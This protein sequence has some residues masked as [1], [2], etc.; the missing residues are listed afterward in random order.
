MESDRNNRKPSGGWRSV[1]GSMHAAM[2]DEVAEGVFVWD[3]SGRCMEVNRTGC[4]LLGYRRDEIVGIYFLDLIYKED[5]TRSVLNFDGVLPG[6]RQDPICAHMQ[7]KDGTL[8]PVEIKQRPLADGNVVALVSDISSLRAA[9]ERVRKTSRLSA[10]LRGIH[11][12]MV[13]ETNDNSLFESTCEIAVDVGGFGLAT[14]GL[15]DNEGLNLKMVSWTSAD[16]SNPSRMPMNIVRLPFEA[17]IL[18]DVIATGKVATTTDLQSVL[19]QMYSGTETKLPSFT[20]GA[21]IPIRRNGSV[22]GLLI[23]GS[24]DTRPM[25]REERAILE[26][27]GEEISFAVDALELRSEMRAL[28]EPSLERF[29]SIM[30]RLSDTVTIL[31]GDEKIIFISRGLE[32]MIGYNS[33]EITGGSF[34]NI[35]FEDDRETASREFAEILQTGKSV[36]ALELRLKR[37][38]GRLVYVEVDATIYKSGSL[39]GIMAVLR[40]VSERKRS[41]TESRTLETNRVE[42]ERQ[43]QQAQR[44]GSIGTLAGGIAHDFN[45]LF[46]IIMGYSMLLRRKKPDEAKLEKGLDSIQNAADRGA[47]LVKQLLTIARKTETVFSPLNVNDIVIEVANKLEEIFPKSISI[48]KTLQ[49]KIPTV[50]ADSGQ[51]NQV[52]MNL[53]MNSKDAMPAGGTL[54]ISTKVAAGDSLRAAY[55]AVESGSYVVLEVADDGTGMSEDTKHRIFDPFFTTK[56]PGK[57]TGLGL[58]LVY[59][60]MESHRG[61][62]DVESEEGRGTIFSLY[63]PVDSLSDEKASRNPEEQSEEIR[64]GRETIFVIEDEEMLQDIMR[65]FLAP[66]GYN[67][68][69]ARDGE[70]ALQIYSERAREIDLV[71]LDLGL[72]KIDGEQ[73]VDR[74]WSIR[75]GAK[76]V[77]A[78]GFVDSETHEKLL[79]AGVISFIPKPYSLRQVLG[80]VREALDLKRR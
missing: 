9:E 33:G 26:E 50:L 27:I 15:L 13:R 5:L 66:K 73:V 47:T 62:I 71:V 28:G 72:P 6:G 11:H 64:G 23:L 8:L 54:S 10:T 17:N 77:V 34:R 35:I 61:W 29:M 80:T 78:S 51:L 12:V 4:N 53:G 56:M 39:T 7:R 46:G 43:L 69:G 79:G 48:S 37:R 44:L 74:I 20:L 19:R 3:R 18:N 70:E 65:N 59:S 67:V 30:D 2:L 57:G 16:G 76:V 45:N 52:L 1:D 42:R 63:F 55:P 38:D 75:P 58:A 14:I 24:D 22:I 68:I 32:S 31:N 60:I 21:G 40:D 25:S 41:A 36:A 49:D